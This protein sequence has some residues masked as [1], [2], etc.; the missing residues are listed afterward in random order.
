VLGIDAETQ[1]NLDGFVELG[2]LHFLQERNCVL[3]NL[4]TLLDCSMRLGDVLS[5][6][7]VHYCSLSPTARR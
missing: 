5:F 3:Q 1:R 6:F 7:F 4:G 2:V